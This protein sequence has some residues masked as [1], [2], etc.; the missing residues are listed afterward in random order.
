VQYEVWYPEKKKAHSLSQHITAPD[1]QQKH[2][3]SYHPEDAKNV[4][5]LPV[6]IHHKYHRYMT[7]D[8]ERM[9]YRTLE[10]VLLDTRESAEAYYA[11]LEDKD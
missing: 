2:H 5:F 3:W 10:G 8:Q 6:L 7:Y 4:F 9:M 11:T 1:G